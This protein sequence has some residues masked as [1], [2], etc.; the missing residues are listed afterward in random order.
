MDNSVTVSG[1]LTRDPELRYTPSGASVCNFSLAVSRRYTKG[2][3]QVEQT[4]FFDVTCWG[5]LAE[6]ASATIQKGH[7]VTVTG[8]LEQRSWETEQH[9]KRS[10]VEIVADDVAPSLKWASAVVE[11]N[12]RDHQPSGSPQQGQAHPPSGQAAA[13]QA[14]PQDHDY[15]EEP[16]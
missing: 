15:S 6:N 4:S 11:R 7:R 5:S 3:E 13:G 8:R 10:K 12:P 9:E 1:N 2:N 16:F 14:P